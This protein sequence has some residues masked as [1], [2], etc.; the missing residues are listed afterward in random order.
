MWL[1]RGHQVAHSFAVAGFL[2][3][4]VVGV[5]A[6]ALVVATA[7][8]GAVALVGAAA[9]GGFAGGFIGSALGGALG[10]M[11]ARTG[12]ILNGSPDVFVND[13][14]VARV[15]D[16]VKCAKEPAPVPII[17]GN[18]G[19][20]VNGLMLA[21]IGHKLMCG[22]VVDEG[23]GNVF[24]NDATEAIAVPDPEVPVW[25]RVAAD[26]LGFL[27]LGAVAARMAKKLPSSKSAQTKGGQPCGQRSCASDPVDVATGEW[28]EVRQDIEIPGVLPLQ[29]RRVYASAADPSRPSLFGPRWADSFSAHI[30]RDDATTLTFWDEEGCGWVFDAPHEGLNAAHLRLPDWRLRG[31]RTAPVLHNLRTGVQTHFAWLG[32]RARIARLQDG[33]GNRATFHYAANGHLVAIAHSAGYQL[34]LDYAGHGLSITLHDQGAAP[35]ELVRYGFDAESRLIHSQGEFSG[36]LYYRYD[37]AHRATHWG[38]A[39]QTHVQLTYDATGR[40]CQVDG[41]NGIHSARFEYDLANRSTRV[42]ENGHATIYRYNPHQLVIERTNP[43]GQCW[44]TEWDAFQQKRSETDP[45][46]RRT[47]YYYTDLGQ[48]TKVQDADG[49]S[50]QLRW[51]DD[52]RCIEQK[53]PDGRKWTWQYNEHGSVLAAD[54]PTD[55]HRFT[56]DSD[57]CLL[58]QT[59]NSITTRFDSDDWQRPCAE[60]AANGAITRIVQSRLGRITS[61]TDA[62]GH[63]TRFEYAEVSPDAAPRKGRHRH[64]IAVIMPNGE[65][66]TYRFDREGML[67]EQT[68]AAGNSQRYQWGAFDLLQSQTDAAGF[69]HHYQYDHLARLRQITNPLGQHWTWQYD[70]AGQ[71]VKEID[72]AGR[73]TIWQYDANGR[74]TSKTAADWVQ[75]RYTYDHRERL[76]RIDTED[77]AIQYAWDNFNRLTE[78]RVVRAGVVESELNWA[79][80]E[81]GRVIGSVQDEQCLAWHYDE[82][83]RITSLSTPHNTSHY[84][85][86]ALGLLQSFTSYGG[87]LYIERD[88]QGQEVRRTSLAPKAWQAIASGQAPFE[89]HFHLTQ[90]FDGVGRM[91]EQAL[92]FQMPNYAPEFPGQVEYRST[93]RHYR[94]SQGRLHGVDDSRFGNV[95]YSRDA[96]D[97]ILRTDYTTGSLRC[98]PDALAQESF[99]Y[100]PVGDIE[101]CDQ[102]SA[103]Q[104]HEP[105]QPFPQTYQSG[106]VNRRGQFSYQHDL[107]GRMIMRTEYRN[108]FRPQTTRFKW[109]GFNRLVQVHTSDGAIWA[110]SYDAFGRRTGKRC[111]K[112]ATSGAYHNPARHLQQETCLWQGA[113]LAEQSKT[114][115]DGSQEHLT[116][117]YAPDSFTPLA[118]TQKRAGQEAQLLYF[119]TDQLGTPREL[120]NAEGKIVWSAQLQTW[121]KANQWWPGRAAN[122]ANNVPDVDLR[123]ANQWYDLETGLHYNYQRYYDPDTGQY[124]SPDPIGVAGGLRP[125]GYVHDPSEWVDPL[126]L[127]GCDGMAHHGEIGYRF[128]KASLRH[129]LRRHSPHCKP[130]KQEPYASMSPN[131][132]QGS[133]FPREW[134]N[135]DIANRDSGSCRQSCKSCSINSGRFYWKSI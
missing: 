78:A 25:A 46:G 124:C 98:T 109:D 63:I 41:P 39:S 47:S 31:T 135:R 12:V 22:A 24:A 8:V 44:L 40:V 95:K 26:W 11:G 2:A 14:P 50:H 81:A 107:C 85:H 7:G 131:R 126:G 116:W 74:V 56:Y 134:S 4:I 92:S 36:Q 23:S 73:E 6:A 67:A 113:M 104:M 51:D 42:I 105:D 115:A 88:L 9:A 38:D 32:A 62:T 49:L 68:S 128:S 61:L 18:P 99:T 106:A 29:L 72:F 125:Q 45:R 77:C 94:W 91:A 15:T 52:G 27:P 64:P 19:I 69:T 76:A 86:D 110:Y 96:R 28:I 1:R 20:L 35:V 108:G 101:W 119:V 132:K 130:P 13:K 30:T 70:A 5:A 43:L 58:S 3:A 17:E 121:G 133:L 21:R 93:L 80:D 54:G 89:Q 120:V 118:L 57:G 112:P 59:E 79:Y 60:I 102:A 65:R 37:V 114:Y 103:A 75:T 16:L 100:N 10:Q 55:S 84:G 97:Q 33:Y 48:L 71:L 83:G 129:I 82:Q 53:A 122:D 34:T 111:I 127:S 123:F 87:E 117:H 66:T 90:R